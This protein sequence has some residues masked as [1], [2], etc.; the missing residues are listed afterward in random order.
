MKTKVRVGV[1][2]TE[3][4]DTATAKKRRAGEV[5][6]TACVRV[7]Q[8]TFT[9]I[10]TLF[11]PKGVAKPAIAARNAE[12]W[13]PLVLEFGWTDAQG[14]VNIPLRDVVTGYMAKMS[15]FAP[16]SVVCDSTGKTGGSMT[17]PRP[18]DA[19]ELLTRMT[20]ARNSRVYDG[21][22]G[23]GPRPGATAMPFT[24]PSASQVAELD[25]VDLTPDSLAAHDQLIAKA[26]AQAEIA[27][28]AEGHPHLRTSR[29][30]LLHYMPQK[31]YIDRDTA[32]AYAVHAKDTLASV[33]T[34][35]INLDYLRG[36]VAAARGLP[37]TGTA[38]LPQ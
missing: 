23:F 33:N 35:V 30:S 22:R 37:P 20:L 6:Y 12:K 1:P 14:E 38:L 10:Y 26:A 9:D 13:N 18:E 32:F 25:D 36:M 11:A 4:A 7:F 2:F 34:H 31:P 15:M 21:Q 16:P 19:L 29:T 17:F 3:A 8:A 24:A 5:D 27:E 28:A